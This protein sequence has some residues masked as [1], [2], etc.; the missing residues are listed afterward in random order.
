MSTQDRKLPFTVSPGHRPVRSFVLRQGRLTAGQQ[1]AL[2]DHWQRYGLDY[3]AQPQN[4]A[5]HFANDRDLVVEIGFGNGDQLL[6]AAQTE[7]QLNFIGIEVHAP[8]VGRLLA[9]AANKELDNL[10]VYCHDAVEVLQHEIADASLAQVRIYFP[11]PW[12]KKRHHKRRLI[13]PQFIELL[14]RKLRHGGMLHLATDWRDYAEHMWQ[15]LGAQT[16]LVCQHQAGTSTDRPDWRRQTH[17]E[18]R[19][20]KLGH[21][22]FDL[23][24][25]RT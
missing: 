3:Q 11:D 12:H 14:C 7:P 2:D 20:L 9:G 24:Y 13:Q 10:R 21:E 15:V 5:T 22:V 23:I 4:F 1:K 17:F 8:G 25:L 19:G 6:F 16:G 18:S